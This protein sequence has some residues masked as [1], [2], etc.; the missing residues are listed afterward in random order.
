[1][2]P[3]RTSSCW[4]ISKRNIT[5]TMFYWPPLPLIYRPR[6]NLVRADTLCCRIRECRL[7]GE[8]DS[9]AEEPVPRDPEDGGAE[10]ERGAARQQRQHQRREQQ[11]RPRSRT[12]QADSESIFLQTS[13]LRTSFRWYLCCSKFE[14]ASSLRNIFPYFSFKLCLTQP[15]PPSGECPWDWIR[16]SRSKRSSRTSLVKLH[17]SRN[18]NC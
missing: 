7:H 2:C 3:V 13:R 17:R 6:P 5:G 4:G 9:D 14:L 18:S 12:S 16:N 11:P 15:Q 1:M 8:A 10:E